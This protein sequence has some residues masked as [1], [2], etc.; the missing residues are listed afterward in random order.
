[1]YWGL[2]V[3][4]SPDKR[5][6]QGA[7]LSEYQP[8]IIGEST[9]LY[10]II[11][12]YSRKSLRRFR[13]RYYTIQRIIHESIS[14]RKAFFCRF[15]WSNQYIRSL[16]IFWNIIYLRQWFSGNFILPMISPCPTVLAYL[17]KNIP[18]SST[19]VKKKNSVLVVGKVWQNVIQNRCLFL[20]GKKDRISSIF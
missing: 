10:T 9:V 4:L 7:T 8:I 18:C 1:M 16:F 17:L 3:S 11:V 6:R 5:S 12:L 15:L 19:H 13:G 2:E 14:A 20:S